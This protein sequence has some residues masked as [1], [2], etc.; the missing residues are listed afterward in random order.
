MSW[1]SSE[2]VKE[3]IRAAANIVDVIG[4]YVQ[5]KRSGRSY[6]GPCPIHGGGGPNFSVDPQKEVYHCFVCG[7]SGDV[8]TFIMEHLGMDFP[9]ALRLL[10]KKVGI[11]V[12]ERSARRE[13]PWI[14]HRE[15]LAFAA[16]WYKDQLEADTGD[17]ARAYL[18]GRGWSLEEARE[19]GIGYAPWRG[20]QE[21]AREI[22]LDEKILLE[23]GLLV[24]GDRTEQP[25]DRFRAR[26]MFTIEDIRDRPIGFG[27]RILD[28]GSKAPKYLNS[29][30]SPVFKKRRELYGLNRAR[31]AIRKAER[32]AIVEGFTDVIA[33]HRADYR[34]AVAGLG[35]AFTKEQAESLL[36][37]TKRAYL[38]YDS[39]AAGQRASFRTGDIL[40][41]VGIHPFVVTL[42]Q[43]ED[44]DSLVRQGGPAA[45][46]Q[47][48]D[49]ADDILESK[50]RILQR[51]G[52]LESADGRRRAL[53]GV[54]S[55]MRA[56]RDAALR[57]IYVERV[58]EALGMRRDT[59]VQE[60]ARREGG[61]RH[62]F[63]SPRGHGFGDRDDHGDHG[64]LGPANG[65]PKTERMLLLLMV[66]DLRYARRA[67][68]LD[69]SIEHLLDTRS[70]EIF[71]AV[72]VSAE[73]GEVSI[74]WSRLGEE[75][76][77]LGEALMADS[78]EV[79]DPDAEFEAAANRLLYRR[80]RER[81]AQIDR[82]VELADPRHL[83][84][85]LKEKE[86]LASELREAGQSG[87]FIPRVRG[88]ES[89]G[90][91]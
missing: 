67:L 79:P 81:L 28:P 91:R 14:A 18:E 43:G 41:N 48:I 80:H 31:H 59:V 21:A 85:L 23:I 56:T 52:F 26:L 35:T 33:L 53:D 29:P 50:L 10:G 73:E 89:G 77:Y 46:E 37:Y 30:E 38:L 63:D 72:V 24:Q 78:E 49:N 61:T 19:Y 71:E 70:R 76:R 4:E 66:R 7:E 17:K 13:D 25:Y 64:E 55:T 57:D 11:E 84:R 69:L 36:R 60:I 8:F 2:D 62:A 58:S 40:M 51:R 16:R 1:R 15:A 82:E 42:P 75:A 34:Y 88:S 22:G 20:F 90:G 6:R 87:T 3:D 86:H 45:L 27:G 74:G 68:R 39:D 65:L 44:P 47:L 32:V 12:P 5:L 9:E 83:R 54:L